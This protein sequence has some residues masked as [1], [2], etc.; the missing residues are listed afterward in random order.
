MGLRDHAETKLTSDPCRTWP[1]GDGR[2]RGAA[3]ECDESAYRGTGCE[4]D[5][6]QVDIGERRRQRFSRGCRSFD[7]C[8]G[9]QLIDLG[10]PL[11]EAFRKDGRRITENLDFGTQMP[12]V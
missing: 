9:G 8:V 5:S 12:K 11:A 2:Q 6:R 3:A 1:D 7:R 4:D 10:T